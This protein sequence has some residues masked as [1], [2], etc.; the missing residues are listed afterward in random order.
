[1]VDVG[2]TTFAAA[3]FLRHLRHNLTKNQL[4]GTITIN[5]GMI[6]AIAV[7]STARL[8]ARIDPKSLSA[9][10]APRKPPS[11]TWPFPWSAGLTA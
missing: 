9:S 7:I 11:A 10:P 6:A 3:R 2:G 4:P 5:Q 8:S 1:M